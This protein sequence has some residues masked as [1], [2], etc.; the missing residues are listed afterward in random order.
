MGD[1]AGDY[2]AENSALHTLKGAKQMIRTHGFRVFSLSLLAVIGLM[3]AA[4]SGASAEAGKVLILNAAETQAT[5][6]HAGFT[7]GVDL[8]GV[9][10]IPTRH[11]TIDCPKYEV[12]EG[13]ILT[14]GIAHIKVLFSECQVW[15]LLPE[16]EL[17]PQ[18]EVYPTTAD[19]TAGT[20]EGHISVEALLL[21]LLHTGTGGSET[22]V[23]AKP[24][25]AGGLFTKIF[26]KE[27][28]A[29]TFADIK[30]EVDFLFHTA[31]HQVEHLAEEATGS[32]KLHQLKYN[33]GDA[34]L[35]GTAWVGLIGEHANYRWGII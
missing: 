7:L 2:L 35:L 18:C 28:S 3:A 26:F 9:L 19:R 23:V 24:K 22:I 27:C 17:Y 15:V 8:L 20:N 11:L 16:L 4:A 5:D 21:V 12:W 31:G 6:L 1:P 32:F 30:G 13:L 25:E 14:G 29:G 33:N 34:N 10:D